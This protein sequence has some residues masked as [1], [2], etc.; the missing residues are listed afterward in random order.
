LVALHE[1]E[2]LAH[3][4]NEE[5]EEPIASQ[6]EDLNNESCEVSIEDDVLSLVPKEESCDAL[7]YLHEE[8]ISIATTFSILNKG[9]VSHCDI[10]FQIYKYSEKSFQDCLY[11]NPIQQWMEFSCS[12]INQPRY[13]L[14]IPLCHQ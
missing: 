8:D 3:P 6:E 9:L 10:P 14:D 13:E 12:G 2:S 11:I 5:L 7:T 1:E 4:K